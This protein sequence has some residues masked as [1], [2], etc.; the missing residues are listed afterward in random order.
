MQRLSLEYAEYMAHALAAE[1]MEWGEPIP[2]F[3]TRFPG[4]L[5]SCLEAPF[6]TYGGD[7]LY[8]TLVD[9]A[10][11]LFYLMIKN[12]PFQNGNKRIAVTALGSF[13]YLNDQ[14]IKMENEKLYNLAIHVAESKPAHKDLIIKAVVATIQEHLVDISD[15]KRDNKLR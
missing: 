10:A 6:S 14:W 12:H 2:P 7:D 5:E 8:P 1:H 13:L 11:I 4:K 15:M 9:K 3:G